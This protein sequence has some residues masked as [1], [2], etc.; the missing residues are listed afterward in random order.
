MPANTT[1]TPKREETCCGAAD[2]SRATDACAEVRPNEDGCCAV[3]VWSP[4][5]GASVQV[6]LN[7]EQMWQ[8][9][10]SYFQVQSRPQQVQSRPQN[11]P[12]GRSR[13][14]PNG[15]PR[16]RTRTRAT[17]GRTAGSR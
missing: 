9:M 15:R 6:V 8:M 17:A 1:R 13:T 12:A 10:R 5:T 14:N 2:F 3:R 16:R 7:Q 4:S 11:E